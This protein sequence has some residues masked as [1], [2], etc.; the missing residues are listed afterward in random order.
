MLHRNDALHR[1]QL[2]L[3]VLGQPVRV[4]V[5]AAGGG[6]AVAEAL[7]KELREEVVGDGHAYRQEST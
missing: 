7:H 6:V 5:A 2:L 1:Q 4:V 3:T